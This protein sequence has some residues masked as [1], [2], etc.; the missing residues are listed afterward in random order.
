V[1]NE[2]QPPKPNQINQAWC[3]DERSSRLSRLHQS[4]TITRCVG[5]RE[6]ASQCAR[7]SGQ[8][9]SARLLLVLAVVLSI[10]TDRSTVDPT[11]R[12]RASGVAAHVALCGAHSRSK[13]ANMCHSG[14]VA[15]ELKK[16][17]TYADLGNQSVCVIAWASL[18]AT[19]RR[20]K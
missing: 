13:C 7:V 14:R 5:D 8:C 4:Y 19:A 11:S 20:L 10:M 15:C 6:G 18:M 3:D 17:K 9:L 12:R 1:D 16:Y 2:E